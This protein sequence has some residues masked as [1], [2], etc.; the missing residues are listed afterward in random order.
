MRP[1]TPRGYRDVL[2]L[3]AAERDALVVRMNDALSRW[4]YDCVET[5]VVERLETLEAAAGGGLETE[6]F[7]LIDSDGPL[8]ALR[9]EMTLPIARLAATR[10]DAD[11]APHRLRYS[12]RVFREQP[13]L[14]GQPREFMQVGVELIGAGGPSADAEVISC[15]ADALSSAGLSTY[16]IGVGTVAVLR[17]LITAA[18]M[19]PEWEAEVLSAAHD[20]NLVALRELAADEAV[21]ADVARALC[22]VAATRGGREAIDVCR[23]LAG[24][25]VAGALDALDETWDLLELQGC[26]ERVSIDFGIM[27]SFDYYTGLVIEAYGSGPGMPLGGGGR[28]DGVLA[29][30][31]TPQAAAGFALRV[32]RV[33][34]ELAAQDVE[35]PVRAL[36]AVLG[37]EPEDVFPAAAQ[38]RRAGWRVRIAPS[39]SRSDVVLAASAAGA[40]YALVAD[41]DGVV[42]IED[43]QTRPVA[44]DSP[45][46]TGERGGA[47]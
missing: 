21:P 27:R 7:R 44:L 17:G 16:T 29:A 38:L 31:E 36:D 30:F 45:P 42:Q 20:R 41:G 18:G 4:G 14:R 47:R 12:G 11:D 6:L 35:I 34:E 32:E 43:G 1:V 15:M 23:E 2:A 39:M 26:A 8:L 40:E 13:S 25:W 28:Y 46:A 37:G 10:L 24:E 22:E 19:Q 5:P 3:E 33:H 9:P